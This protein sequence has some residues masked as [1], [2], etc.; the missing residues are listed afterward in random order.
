MS[1]EGDYYQILGITKPSDP[2]EIKRAYHKM[3]LCWHPDKNQSP[4]ASEQF[5]KISEA[6]DI[7]STPEKKEIYDKYGQDG[8]HQRSM[9]FNEANVF[10]IFSQCGGFPGGF[11]GFPRFHD[12]PGAGHE[13]IPPIEVTVELSL[14]D[15]FT[16]KNVITQITRESYCSDCNGT[17]FSD[18]VKRICQVCQGRKTVQQQI[19]MGPMI[20]I[21]IGPCSNCKGSG[22]D[23]NTN[24]TC[25]TCQ[26]KTVFL[27]QVPI[28]YKI[29]RSS[30]EQDKYVI[31][32]CGHIMKVEANEQ[33]CPTRGDVVMSVRIKP[34]DVFLRNSHP[35]MTP[36]DLLVHIRLSLVESLCGFKRTLH[37]VSG[38]TLVIGS[39]E[40]I[41]D[42]QIYLIENEGLP[43]TGRLLVWYHVE[44]PQRLSL[45]QKVAIHDILENRP[46][47]EERTKILPVMMSRL[48]H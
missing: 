26:G 1:N 18:K 27:E 7:L 29:P 23:K 35:T 2:S 40:V 36:Y 3:A 38:K 34:H 45:Q 15:V 39:D 31:K 6:Y 13:I 48:N 10:N 17:G 14:E 37:H 12:F 42:G 20:T 5:K 19:R 44:A 41:Q 32:N 4:H 11:S 9:R 46:Y 16:E 22:L 8:L 47:I 33:K 24:H 30:L 28:T 25:Q 21:N 43:K